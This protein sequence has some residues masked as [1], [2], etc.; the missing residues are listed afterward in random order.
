MI[1]VLSVEF[2]LNDYETASPLRKVNP[3]S[4]DSE[5]IKKFANEDEDVSV[6]VRHSK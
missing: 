2:S 4:F 3:G 1:Q 5:E 6:T